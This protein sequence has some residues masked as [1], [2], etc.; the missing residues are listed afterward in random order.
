VVYHRVRTVN[1]SLSGG[2]LS[3]IA[4]TAV[5]QT[6]IVG[7]PTAR[8]ERVIMSFRL[9]CTI[10]AAGSPHP[11][12]SWISQVFPAVSVQFDK[13]NPPG[14]IADPATFDDRILAFE[15]LRKQYRAGADATELYAVDYWT[16]LRTDTDVRRRAAGGVGDTPAVTAYLWTYD[17]DNWWSSTFWAGRRFDYQAE[18]T[19]FYSDT[20]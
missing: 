4:A 15:P 19:M 2:V 6:P 18:M 8:L 5:A 13:V 17:V 3:S 14:T 9:T 10:L 16:D 20:T 1:R 7:H 11:P 12:V